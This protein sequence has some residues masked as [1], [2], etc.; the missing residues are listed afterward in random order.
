MIARVGRPSGSSAVG[1]ERAGARGDGLRRAGVRRQVVARV[2]AAVAGRPALRA[3]LSTSTSSTRRASRPRWRRPSA[4]EAAQLAAAALL[5]RGRHR[6]A[7][8]SASVPGAAEKLNVCTCV[9]PAARTAAERALEGRVVLGRIADDH[10]GRHVHV[11]DRCAA[12]DRRRRRSSWPSASSAATSRPRTHLV[13]ATAPRRLAS[14]AST[15]GAG[16]RAC[17]TSSRRAS[18]GSIRAVEKFDWRKGFRFSH[19]RDAVDPP[20]ASSAAWPTAAARSGCPAN[21]AQRE[22]HDRRASSASWRR[23]L[24][25]DADDRARSQTRP[26]SRREQVAELRDVARVVDAAWSGPS[27]TRTATALGQLLPSDGGPRRR[28]GRDLAAPGP[29]AGARWPS[30]PPAAPPRHRSWRDFASASA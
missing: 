22:R 21:V 3:R 13:T 8:R 11:P 7:E 25:D 5:L 19:L 30:S 4:S 2:V 17:S 10:V 9:M 1:V 12:L 20:G 23:E 29:R 18:S 14:P 24:G 16:E 28:G 27:A 6:V 26:A 15:S